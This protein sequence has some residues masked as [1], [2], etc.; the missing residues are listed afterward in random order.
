MTFLLRLLLMLLLT[1]PSLIA[2]TLDY[3]YQ[4]VFIYNF[5][6]YIQ[7]PQ[8]EQSNQ[9]TIGVLGNGRVAQQMSEFFTGR[10]ANAKKIVVKAF[11]SPQELQYTQVLF[12]PV[13]NRNN[14][15][16]ILQK[17]GSQATLL[18]TEKEGWGRQ[19]SGI[20]FVIS[21]E[22]K[23]KFELNEAAVKKHN[24]KVSTSI[25]SLAIVL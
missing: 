23:Y 11:A 2:Q 4:S 8:Q 3:R 21:E 1:T 9:I 15:T 24:L 18:I 22:G 13:S 19:G 10:S 14:L 12:V 6:Q 17:L 25:S 16:E 5:C 7:W 20:N